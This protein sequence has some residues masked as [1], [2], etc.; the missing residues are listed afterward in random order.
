V[1]KLSRVARVGKIGGMGRMSPRGAERISTTG[2][3]IRKLDLTPEPL[4]VWARRIGMDRARAVWKLTERCIVGTL[5]ELC[6]YDWLESHEHQFEF[7]SAQM[8]G[9]QTS[10]GAVIDVLVFD[11]SCDGYYVWRVQGEY[12][13]TLGDVEIKDA[14]QAGRLL[15][16][17]IGGV[18]VAAV[19]DLWENDI[20]DRF[21]QVFEQAEFGVGLRG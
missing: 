18:P 14:A 15:R 13:H 5:P 3:G 17:R 8:G 12:W 4:R 11:L 16:L 9:R 2:G 19:V 20:Y 21:P 7:Q 10:G 6:A 1:K